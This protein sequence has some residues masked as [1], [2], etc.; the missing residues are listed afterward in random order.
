LSIISDKA[1]TFE[2]E[3]IIFTIPEENEEVWGNAV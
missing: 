3:A 2:P 1:T